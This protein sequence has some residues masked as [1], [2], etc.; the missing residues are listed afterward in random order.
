MKRNIGYLDRSLRYIVAT[1]ICALYFASIVTGILAVILAGLAVYAVVTAALGVSPI[2][3]VL[4]LDTDNR[5][6]D[7]SA[8]GKISNGANGGITPKQEIQ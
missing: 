5:F 4:G 2:Y 1:V 6:S 3:G 7:G 8:P